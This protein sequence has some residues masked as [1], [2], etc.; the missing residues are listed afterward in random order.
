MQE[1]PGREVEHGHGHAIWNGVENL[2]RLNKHLISGFFEDRNAG[3]F[4]KIDF[5]LNLGE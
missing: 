1:P 5:V 3:R 4:V 2:R